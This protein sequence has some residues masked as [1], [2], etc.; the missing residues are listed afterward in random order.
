MLQTPA[1]AGVCRFGSGKLLRFV[2]EVPRH[3]DCRRSL[4]GE[5]FRY[6]IPDCWCDIEPL[7]ANAR[8]KYVMDVGEG[9]SVE[10]FLDIF[11][12]FDQQSERTAQ[13]LLD[14]DGVYDFGESVAW[15]L[16]RRF[17][18]GARMSF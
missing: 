10:F 3:R 5:A 7:A 12:V 6:A 16:P 11:N 4:Q 15:V 9:T 18:L 13:D 17:Y 2:A 8:A 14:G 1:S